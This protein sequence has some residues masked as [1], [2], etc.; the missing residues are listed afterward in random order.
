M[1]RKNRLPEGWIFR[2]ATRRAAEFMSS[3]G[4]GEWC[5]EFQVGP[6]WH[7]SDKLSRLC[8]PKHQRPLSED[9]K[10]AGTVAMDSVLMSPHA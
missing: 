2:P 6:D 7:S 4:A 8:E 5:G 1:T 9:S 10:L 3:R